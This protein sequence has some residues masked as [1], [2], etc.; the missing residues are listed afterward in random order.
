MCVSCVLKTLLLL[1]LQVIDAAFTGSV[2][3]IGG[4][5]LADLQREA[6]SFWAKGFPEKAMSKL[7]DYGFIQSRAKVRPC[8]CF[9]PAQ[10]VDNAAKPALCS[11][12]LFASA[13]VRRR[14]C[15]YVVNI[16]C[17]LLTPRMCSWAHCYA[18]AAAAA[19][20]SLPPAG[21]YHLNNQTI[22]RLLD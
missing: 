18:A 12:L 15:V 9:V 16:G 22:T 11:C 17:L 3:R 4:M 2:S 6:E 5:N 1:L 10:C 14:F 20:A 7:E 21:E 8:F 19:A 13:M